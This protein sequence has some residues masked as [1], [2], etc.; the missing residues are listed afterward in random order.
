MLTPILVILMIFALDEAYGIGSKQL[1]APQGT[2]LA[3]IIQGI[4]GDDMPRFK[5][6]AG[7]GLGVLLSSSGIGGLGI[8]VGLGFYLSFEVV[9]TYTIGTFLR[10]FTDWRMGKQFSEEVGIPIAAG[11]IVGEALVG[12]GFAL[13]YVFSGGIS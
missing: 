3:S 8:L 2:A 10:V 7:A 11:F 6:M 12:V 5:Y 1:P 9:L 4:Q 13:Y